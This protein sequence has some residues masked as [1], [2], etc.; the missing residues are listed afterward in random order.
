MVGG[1]R[2]IKRSSAIGWVVHERA[3]GHGG[4]RGEDSGCPNYNSCACAS[5]GD[6]VNGSSTRDGDVD[7]RKS[8]DSSSANGNYAG[9][10]SGIG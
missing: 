10:S 2:A 6:S 3:A 8:T 7:G 9:G 5:T 1:S 4:G